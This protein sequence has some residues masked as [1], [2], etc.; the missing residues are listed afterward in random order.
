MVLDLLTAPHLTT[1]ICMT[2]ECKASKTG[3]KEIAPTARKMTETTRRAR[4][5]LLITEDDIESMT[6]DELIT[7]VK[8]EKRENGSSILELESCREEMMTMACVL[9]KCISRQRRDVCRH[10]DDEA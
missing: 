3:R 7:L 6:N 8:V 9:G 2:R 1:T 4:R 10:I 5:I